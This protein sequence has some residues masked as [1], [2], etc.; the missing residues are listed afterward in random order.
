MWQSFRFRDGDKFGFQIHATNTV[1]YRDRVQKYI[2]N[3]VMPRIKF[4]GQ[5]PS[6]R[7][8]KGR[9]QKKQKS[10]GFNLR[11]KMWESI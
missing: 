7:D 5:H 9:R 4:T 1:A 2:F 3:V 10:T 11:K 6:E 8:N